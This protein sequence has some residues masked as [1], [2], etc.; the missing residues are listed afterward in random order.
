MSWL[1]DP[2]SLSLLVISL[3]LAHAALAIHLRDGAVAATGGNP[4]S[5]LSGTRR[6]AGGRLKNASAAVHRSSNAWSVVAERREEAATWSFEPLSR[7][8]R[9]ARRIASDDKGLRKMAPGRGDGRRCSSSLAPARMMMG[10]ACILRLDRSQ[11]IASRPGTSR[12]CRSM[13][14]MC[15]VLSRTAIK[16]PM[17]ESTISTEKPDAS[18][19]SRHNSRGP[20]SGMT[21]RARR[22]YR[23]EATVGHEAR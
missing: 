13:R 6:C 10:V 16:A 20:G 4:R 3:I 5:K 19:T 12:S 8:S 14:I 18:R 15:V 1:D 21:T 2:A 17:P 7:T 9:M 23:K 11:P 22:I